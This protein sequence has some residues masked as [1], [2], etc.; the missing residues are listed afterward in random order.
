MRD[1]LA[2]APACGSRVPVA[3]RPPALASRVIPR[4]LGSPAFLTVGLPDEHR[5]PGPRR[6]CHVPHETATTG[7]GALCTPGTVVRSRP[8]KFPR[9]APAAS[10]RPVP[11]SHCI[12]PSAGVLMT[13]RHR[14]FTCVHPSGL[15]QPVTPD[16][17]AVL[18]QFLGLRTPQLPATH[19]EAGTVLA[20]WTGHYTF[21][22]SR[23]SF[24]AY[25]C[26]HATSCRTTWFNHDAWTGRWIRVRLDHPP[27][28]RSTEAWPRW[29]E[30]LSTT[31]NTRSAEA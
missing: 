25:H 24:G 13:R 4:P 15:P 29:L 19:A 16:G 3:F 14:G 27:C 28:S 12:N 6:G 8:A 17:T 20:H 9:P 11:I 10:Q 2:E 30:P 21:N 7:M 26:S 23:T 31:Q 22:L 5:P 1:P 18:G